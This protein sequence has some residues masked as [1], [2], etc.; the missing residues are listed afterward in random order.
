MDG[1]EA[2]DG[3]FIPTILKL[4]CEAG[5]LLLLLLRVSLAEFRTGLV[6]VAKAGWDVCV[7]VEDVVLLS[8]LSV[9]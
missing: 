8:V 9:L 6:Y 5:K 1:T 3:L 2:A 7:C 4:S